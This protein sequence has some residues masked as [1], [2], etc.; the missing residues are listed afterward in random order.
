MT[1]DRP[2]LDLPY[3]NALRSRRY[4]SSL[5]IGHAPGGLCTGYL[6]RGASRPAGST[7]PKADVV[8]PQASRGKRVQTRAGSSR[9]SALPVLVTARQTAPHDTSEALSP[10]RFHRSTRGSQMPRSARPTT[11]RP[12]PVWIR[13]HVIK[14]APSASTRSQQVCSRSPSASTT[15]P[16]TAARSARRSAPSAA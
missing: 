6:T 11:A 4:R 2:P 5:H 7:S 12:D 15:K 3:S 8:R 9:R 10:P 16:S 14:C 13:A 1:I